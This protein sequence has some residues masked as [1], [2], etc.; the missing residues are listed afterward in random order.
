[1]LFDFEDRSVG[2]CFRSSSF[3]DMVWILKGLFIDSSTSKSVTK[4]ELCFV[5]SENE[6]TELLLDVRGSADASVLRCW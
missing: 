1:M 6:K 5:D 2:L 3:S 4:T